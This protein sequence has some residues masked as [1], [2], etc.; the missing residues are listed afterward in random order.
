MNRIAFLN[1]AIKQSGCI[2]FVFFIFLCSYLHG[3]QSS[4]KYNV[5][6][7]MSSHPGSPRDERFFSSFRKELKKKFPAARVFSEYLDMKRFSDKRQFEREKKLLADK[8]HAG[9][10]NIVVCADY[11][12]LEFVV[13]VRR[14]LF[15]KV[16]VVFG[17]VNEC[18][19]VLLKKNSNI[20]GIV[21]KL[22]M[23][24]IIDVVLKL[25]P[26]TKELVLIYDNTPAG[27]AYRRIFDAALPE[28]FRKHHRLEV[29]YLSGRDLTTEQMISSLT[30][31]SPGRL[32][33]WGC[34]F[35]DVEGNWIDE[36]DLNRRLAEIDSIP[37]FAISGMMPGVMGAR[38]DSMAMQGREAAGMAAA[39]LKGAMADS[40]PVKTI[41]A[42]E[43][44]FD[45]IALDR[46]GVGHDLLPP[47]VELLNR[48]FMETHSNQILIAIAMLVIQAVVI[49]LLGISVTKRIR[50]ERGMSEISRDFS[51]IFNSIRDAVIIT[52]NAGVIKRIN[53]AA[54]ELCG[55]EKDEAIGCSVD[56]VLALK[57]LGSHRSLKLPLEEVL[58]QRK[59]VGSGVTA[60]MTSLS[61]VGHRI[62]YTVSPVINNKNTIIGVI[63]V[64]NDV[65]GE[66]KS[67]E[68]LMIA[69]E[70]F[71]IMFDHTPVMIALMTPNG[72]P[73]YYNKSWIDNSGYSHDALIKLKHEEMNDREGSRKIREATEKISNK[74]SMRAS[75]ERMLQLPNGNSF[76]LKD[77]ILPVFDS[78]G[79]VK[80]LIDISTNISIEAKARKELKWEREQRELILD[81]ASEI[82][83]HLDQNMCVLWTNRNPGNPSKSPDEVVGMHYHDVLFGANTILEDC[84]VRKAFVSGQP[85]S[86]EVTTA[87]GLALLVSVAPVKEESRH[88]RGAVVTCM[89]MTEVRSL[90]RQLL[91]SQKMDAVGKLAG[92]VAHDFNNI[93]QVVLGYGDLIKSKLNDP[94]ALKMW[95]NVLDA[96]KSARRLVRQLLTFSRADENSSR[97]VEDLND[98]LMNF[99]KMIVRVLGED[100]NFQLKLDSDELNVNMDIGQIEQVLMNLCVNARDAMPHGGK[101]TISAFETDY[102]PVVSSTGGIGLRG[103]FACCEITDTGC[104]IPMDVQSRIFEPFFTT[105]EAGKGTGLG[106]ATSYAI[107]ERHDGIITV[108]S[109]IDKGT[110]FRF[111]LPMADV[112]ALPTEMLQSGVDIG[113]FHSAKGETILLVEDEPMVMEIGT[114]LLKSA[115]YNVIQAENGKQGIEVFDANV[116]KIDLA[117]LDVI[118]PEMSGKVVAEHIEKMK[119]GV[120]ILF[121]SGYT[122]DIIDSSDIENRLVR[123]P[124]NPGL[125]LKRIFEEL[126]RHNRFSENGEKVV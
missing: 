16:P 62:N 8:Y 42:N 102:A 6:C 77:T 92:G 17:G 4:R 101:L 2:F 80:F 91:H 50:A 37:L 32:G 66:Y 74:S 56:K 121:C 58:S 95:D 79:K 89:D 81:N 113:L 18:E 69:E 98:V 53:P 60:D 87:D 29:K 109:A 27:Q 19:S 12:A 11:E 1:K 84:P 107:I 67:R 41:E 25:F 76:E 78:R 86:G 75:F 90:E 124:Y 126:E 7:L 13:K 9:F 96:G 94:K 10:L 116:D 23:Q 44:I 97:T 83:M 72:T 82:I 38:N 73:L 108:N 51:S 34:W 99:K 43:Y 48:P 40:L 52:N 54:L 114:T 65:T 125:L 14:A 46:W 100:I 39:I 110:V 31:F 85:Q 59:V 71:R 24:S 22:N 105:K 119:P 63:I 103:R 36:N 5:L 68:S 104:G 33:L 55:W 3:E 47:G 64:L 70:R 106:L 115:G 57:V 30:V 26:E 28:V 118:L 123:K 111:F 117:L 15:D 61:G 112:A 45:H 120:P 88:I 21:S 49:V 93:I 122:A 35:R 20:T